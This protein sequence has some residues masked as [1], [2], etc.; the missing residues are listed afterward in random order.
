MYVQYDG[1]HDKEL[2]LIYVKTQ[3]RPATARVPIPPFPG[4]APIDGLRHRKTGRPAEQGTEKRRA[5]IYFSR[6]K[7]NE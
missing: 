4:M 2:F 6:L 3:R 7:T 1:S 5:E